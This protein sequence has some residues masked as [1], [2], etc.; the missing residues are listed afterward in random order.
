MHPQLPR[1]RG[2]A[3]APASQRW[4]R[5]AGSVGAEA[6][7]T[8]ACASEA[9]GSSSSGC[10][11][12]TGSGRGDEAAAAPVEPTETV[13]AAS[14]RG[15]AFHY[16]AT[17]PGAAH[18][19][20]DSAASGEAAEPAAPVRTA[21]PAEPSAPAASAP[22]ATPMT[23]CASG[24]AGCSVRRCRRNCRNRAVRYQRQPIRRADC[25]A[26]GTAPVYSAPVRPPAPP[27]SPQAPGMRPQGRTSRTRPAN[28]PASAS[29]AGWSGWPD[30]QSSADASGRAPSDASDTFGSDG[31]ASDGRR[32]WRRSSRLRPEASGRTSGAVAA[33]GTAL[34]SAWGEGRPDE[35]L[36]SAAAAWWLSNE[37]LPITRT[38]RSP[39]A[40][41]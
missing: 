18:C 31:S 36:R 24:R 22:S 21:K 10:S 11:R 7:G 23:A 15:S 39:K 17:A 41:A 20:A 38:S 6:G 32:C 26:D 12:G 4:H 29:A 33:S 9:S 37:P 27:A 5:A 30:G 2:T 16:A 25:S 3:A 35:G 8:A 19:C 40:S 14:A 28:F 13:R 1:V 34:C